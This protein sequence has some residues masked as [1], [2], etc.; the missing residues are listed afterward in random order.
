VEYLEVYKGTDFETPVFDEAKHYLWPIPFE[1]FH[2]IRQLDKILD[3][4][5]NR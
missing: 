1:P 3:G 5:V 2:K 4:D